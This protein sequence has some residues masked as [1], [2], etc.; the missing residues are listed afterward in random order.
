MTK[1]KT[2]INRVREIPTQQYLQE[3]FDY[4]PETGDLIWKQRPIQHFDNNIKKQVCWNNRFSNR[5]AGS[6][7]NNS[8][9]VVTIDDIRLQAH[10]II[11]KMYYGEDIEGKIEHI[12]ENT[13]DN[14]IV[15]LKKYVFEDKPIF[16]SIP[17]QEY[18]KECF[19]YNPETGILTWKERPL[20]HFSGKKAYNWFNSCF[21][22]KE[23]RNT[24]E[25]GYV[26]VTINKKL[27]LVHRIIW[28]LIYN[29]HP[30]TI[31][32]IN[33]ITDD[34]RL[35]NLRNVTQEQNMRNIKLPRHNNSG[36]MGASKLGKRWRSRIN[37]GDEEILI[38]VFDT[39]EEAALAYQL[40]R[41]ELYGEDFCNANENNKLLIEELQIKV[42]EILEVG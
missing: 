22:N 12:N 20:Y 19:D 23:L 35:C 38:G 18:L 25:Y 13:L 1:V 2:K 28:M 3:C 14:R 5:N 4:N 6:V 15:N 8:R 31:D 40:K 42:K 11:W 30:D 17:T 33:G 26:Y 7:Y 9:L 39:K 37:I 41:L 36:Y 16:D 27:Y 34:N 32:H 21:T 24:N 29:E 10:H